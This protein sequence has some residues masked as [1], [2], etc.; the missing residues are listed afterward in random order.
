MKFRATRGSRNLSSP[1]LPPNV[2]RVSYR[3]RRRSFSRPPPFRFPG[4]YIF[5]ARRLAPAA[6]SVGSNFHNEI[7]VRVCVSCCAE[8]HGFARAL[9]ARGQQ[10]YPTEHSS[11]PS[12]RRFEKVGKKKNNNKK[13]T[14]PPLRDHLG[15][16]A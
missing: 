5:P 14:C 1:L 12:P 3:D 7:T 16:V 6:G 2:R 11:L 4:K 15:D 9:L 13:G 10:R 8:K